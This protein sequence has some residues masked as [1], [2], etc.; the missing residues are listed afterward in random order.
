MRKRGNLFSKLRE[1]GC[2]FFLHINPENTFKHPEIVHPVNIYKEC[3]NNGM[4]EYWSLERI[5]IKI[6]HP[7]I[8]APPFHLSHIPTFHPSSTHPTLPA[9]HYSIIPTSHP[10]NIPSFQ[11]F[12][13]PHL[14]PHYSTI[15]VVNINKLYP[16]SIYYYISPVIGIFL[17]QKVGF[18]PIQTIGFS[19]IYK[20]KII[21]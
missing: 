21:C 7:D 15:P 20:F 3:W 10:S 2:P 11:H 18:F 16:I 1:T 4:L 14:T 5:L 19:P 9:F 17:M 12:T 13:T 8:P 6:Q